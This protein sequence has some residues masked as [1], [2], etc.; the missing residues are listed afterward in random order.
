MGIHTYAI[1]YPIPPAVGQYSQ[2]IIL[3]V[4]EAEGPP[5]DHLHLVVEASEYDTPIKSPHETG[6]SYLRHAGATTPGT[7]A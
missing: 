1:D 5:G 4:P 2:S 3:K 7:G 6:K